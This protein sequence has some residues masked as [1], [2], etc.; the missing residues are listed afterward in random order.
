MPIR[1]GSSAECRRRGFRLFSRTEAWRLHLDRQRQCRDAAMLHNPHYDFNDA[2]LSLGASYRVRLA[3]SILPKD[4][5]AG[6]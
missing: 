4:D 5:V 6:G 1:N 2:I 3:E